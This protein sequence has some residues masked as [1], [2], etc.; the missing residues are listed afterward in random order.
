MGNHLDGIKTLSPEA[1]K[2]CSIEKYLNDISSPNTRLIS[3]VHDNIEV[4]TGEWRS[5][6]ALLF[7]GTE[8]T[9]NFLN[10]LFGHALY[11]S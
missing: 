9:C 2:M 4:D 1:F 5:L 8:Q 3:T 6:S 10:A 7:S 11:H